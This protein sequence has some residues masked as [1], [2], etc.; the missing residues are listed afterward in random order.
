MEKKFRAWDKEYKTFFYFTLK[1]LYE[2]GFERKLEDDSKHL[3][4]STDYPY[5]NEEQYIGL[6]DKNGKEIYEGD[7]LKIDDPVDESKIEIMYKAPGFCKI[8]VDRQYD[9]CLPLDDFD[10]SHYVIIGNIH[11]GVENET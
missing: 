3:A 5:V 11:S 9:Y 7:V 10:T 8:P 1:D 6:I 2:E 4:I